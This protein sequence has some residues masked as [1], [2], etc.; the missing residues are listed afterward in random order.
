V[1]RLIPSKAALK[2]RPGK[3]LASMSFPFPRISGICGEPLG[4]PQSNDVISEI[5]EHFE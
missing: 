2:S 1:T 5:E 3:S 4:P